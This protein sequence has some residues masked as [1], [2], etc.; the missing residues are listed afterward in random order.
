MRFYNKGKK[1]NYHN[2]PRTICDRTFDAAGLADGV[3]CI[4]PRAPGGSLWGSVHP[5]TKGKKGLSPLPWRVYL[6]AEHTQKLVLGA[7]GFIFSAAEG[8][9]FVTLHPG[10]SFIMGGSEFELQL[11]CN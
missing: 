6:K 3:P 4:L 7:H 2:C 11:Q 8:V 1:T 5:A 10:I 9:R